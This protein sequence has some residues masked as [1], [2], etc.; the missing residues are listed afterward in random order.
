MHI[1]SRKILRTSLK[2]LL[3]FLSSVIA[4]VVLLLI[5]IR[6][7]TGQNIIRKKANSY[8]SEKTGTEISINRL[9]TNLLSHLQIS[10]ITIKDQDKKTLLHVGNIETEFNILA[11]LKNTLSIQKVNI[12]TLY[13]RMARSENDSSFNFDF[14]IKAFA[15]SDSVVSE[16]QKPET[17]N[18]KAMA[19]DIGSITINQL[20][21]LMDD[22][23]ASQQY[24][25]ISESLFLDVKKL[26]LNKQIYELKTFSTEGLAADINIGNS[27]NESETSDTSSSVLPLVSVKKIALLNSNVSVRISSAGLQTTSKIGK[28]E[29]DNANLDLNASTFK[30]VNLFLIKHQSQVLISALP[31]TTKSETLPAQETTEQQAFSVF[32]DNLQLADNELKYDNGGLDFARKPELN[33][34]HLHVSNLQ[35]Q[36]DGFS[37]K[38]D[39]YAGTIKR[40]TATEQCGLEIKQLETQFSYSDTAINISNLIFTT[41]SSAIMGN[42]SVRYKSL[43]KISTDIGQ[44]G[45]SVHM[46]PIR[47]APAD[48][49]FFSSFTGNDKTLRKLTSKQILL[50]ADAEGKISDLLIEKLRL[51]I[52]KI[53]LSANGKTQGL[54]DANQMVAN[55]NLKEFSGT[56]K[57]LT[58][59]LPAGSIPPTLAANESFNVNGKLSANK[60]NYTTDLYLLSSAGDMI[61]Q[62]EARQLSDER[63]FDYNLDLSSD[64]LELGKILMDTIFGNTAFSVQASGS[65]ISPQT[66]DASAHID[67]IS[68]NYKGYNYESVILDASIKS[69][70]IDAKL[71]STD[72]ALDLNLTARYSLD[73]LNPLIKVNA[74]VR[75]ID[76]YAL[77]FSADTIKFKTQLNAD[78]TRADAS[79]INGTINIPSLDLTY[80]HSNYMFDSISLI[81]GYSD[82]LQLLEL[83]TPFLD[84]DLNGNYEIEILPAVAQNLAIDYITVYP[85]TGT[86]FKPAFAE[87]KGELRYHPVFTGFVP[88]IKAMKNITFSGDIN[89]EKRELLLQVDMPGLVYADYA[90]DSAH[91]AINTR[92][93]TLRYSMELE[94][95][96][97]PSVNLNKT[98]LSGKAKDGVIAWQLE[99]YNKNDSIRYDLSGD[100]IN[101]STKMTLHLNEN[102]LI[103]SDKWLC[104]AGNTIEYSPGHIFSDLELSSG[105]HKLK[106]QSD[107]GSDLPVDLSL[108]DFPISTIT[109]IIGTD[110]TLASG[111]INGTARLSD[112]DP[113]IFNV[114][115]KIDSLKAFNN[116][117]GQLKASGG[118]TPEKS[119]SGKV[120]IKGASQDADIDATYFENGDIKGNLDL[121]KLDIA[122]IDPFIKTI[123]RGL[124]GT[125]SGEV[126]FGGNVS[127]PELKGEILVNELQGHYVD[128]NTF[129]RISDEKIQLTNEGIVLQ[130][131]NAYDSTGN[132]ATVN[133]TILTTDYQNYN[134]DLKVKTDHFMAL[135]KK[136]FPEQEI[137]GPAWISSDLRVSSNNNI[138]MIKGDVKLDDKS[139]LNMEI[140]SIDTNVSNNEGIIVFVDSIESADSAVA[141]SLKMIS[142]KQASSARLGLAMNLEV[143]KASKLNIYLDKSGGDYLKV[144]GD[145]NLTINQ[146]PGGE[147]AMQGK[148]MIDNGEYQ[149]ML[150]QFLKRKFKVQK[151]SYIQ[152]TGSPTDA[153]IDITALYAVETKA[154]AILSGSQTT[155]SGAAKQNLVFEVYL[156]LKNKLLQP[157]IS[158]KLDM[159]VKDQ[160]AFNGIVYSRIKQ[161][162]QNESE[163]NKQVMGLLI[164]NSFIPADP[165]ASSGSGGLVLYDYE[166]AARNTAGNIISQQLNSLIGSRIKAIDV[167]F[168]LNS[169]ADYSTGKK[170]NETDLTVNMSRSMFND[171]YTFSVGSTFALEGSNEH[172]RNAGGLAGN[173]AAEYKITR[174]GRYRLKAYRRDQYETDNSG[175]VVQTGLNLVLFIDFNK[176]REFGIKRKDIKLKD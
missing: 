15:S 84:M 105:T 19:F 24:D 11:L 135:N 69:S 102:Q 126:A 115:L 56:I 42:A 41:P 25:V 1:N 72:S 106:L 149:M 168:D 13:F 80:G 9:T 136:S 86:I 146:Q 123:I 67:L 12:D 145:A 21:F 29:L 167:D 92:N 68:A 121:K 52:D 32:I 133:G 154:E 49:R 142:S 140:S 8:L 59:L 77:K 101:D 138:L 3:Y 35:L 65:G 34:D 129:F 174:D 63:E 28:L 53:T 109:R 31:E 54:P 36:L 143:T 127:K 20:H 137:Y 43:A 111:T 23:Y 151:D 14:I 70:V 55:I 156:H 157:A 130:D 104:N 164:L 88:D 22:K 125:L 144:S 141:Q 114:D 89:T 161:I 82:S 93:D 155:N 51:Q 6:T 150:N 120:S 71:N 27:N 107:A 46:N 18:K 16:P 170:S 96:T 40:L 152:W 60:G 94:K 47:L 175:Q 74:D 118:S 134:Y 90:V 5:F 64:G 78:L 91:F 45:L 44:L 112:L 128:Y 166:S 62:A 76:L 172:K 73:S 159:P 169:R 30:T 162:N 158:F 50:E 4:I 39:I 48:M 98:L 103:N 117:L 160:N 176:Y 26:D 79:H 38:D 147:M 87:L 61:L 139:E 110:T 85:P 163:L 148:F 153:D 17:E 37:M 33:T 95:L 81:A 7:E 99:L 132:K 108:I 10:G 75:N 83:R 122:V 57:S 131:F 2:V 124:K 171:R 173:Y 165:L 119:Y 113:L 66:A 97:S 100:F 116:N 58:G